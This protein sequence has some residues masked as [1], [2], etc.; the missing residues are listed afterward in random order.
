[1]F[2]I[3]FLDLDGVV[4]YSKWYTNPRNPGNLYGQEGEIDPLCIER[5]NKIC[6][7]TGAYIVI[8]S[9][10]RLDFNA[11]KKRLE[12]AGLTGIIVGHTPIHSF[13]M[14]E[15]DKSRGREIERYLQE[16][17]W[18]TDYVIIDDRTDFKEEQLSH[19]VYVAPMYG[20][21]DKH[22]EKAIEILQNEEL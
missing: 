20:L 10:W 6:S 18:F 17:P 1:M 5:I 21:T 4:N 2:G 13:D 22:V 3:I 14:T 9:D 12:K 16:H 11:C 7:E 19:F 15:T 8:S